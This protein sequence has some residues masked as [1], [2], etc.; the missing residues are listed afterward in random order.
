MLFLA[1]CSPP[2]GMVPPGADDAGASPPTPDATLTV[3]TGAVQFEAIARSYTASGTVQPFEKLVVTPRTSGLALKTV[4]VAENT[5]VAAGEVLAELD[6]AEIDAQIAEQRAQLNSRQISVDSARVSVERGKELLASKA[7]SQETAEERNATLG[8]AE[9]DL[10]Q[11]VAALDR[12]TIQKAQ[13]TITA[14]AAG[15]VTDVEARLG[16]IVQAGTELFHITRDGRLEVW[17]QVPEQYVGR[18]DIGAS[19]TIELSQG[20]SSPGTVR[21]IS[22]VVEATTRLATVYVSV[23][24]SS[25]LRE[26]MSARARFA[27]A[28][29]PATTVDPAALVWRGGSPGVF[30]VGADKLVTFVP[31]TLGARSKDRI[32]VAGSL[33]PGDV[34]VV[35]GAGFLNDRDRVLVQAEPSLVGA[36]R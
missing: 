3:T 6:T 32:A 5:L 14:P 36:R 26:G 27:F 17:A 2:A 28:E 21:G 31:A 22:P 11:T 19:V 15:L 23:P 1:A 7:I 10:A 29:E 8:K 35:S 18:I 9:A 30:V 25:G 12:L 24:N 4:N 34:V 13:A 33:I 16:S 20:A